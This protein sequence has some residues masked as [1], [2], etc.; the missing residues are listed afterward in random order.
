[1]NQ[2]KITESPVA[3]ARVTL[4]DPGG[5]TL[6][7]ADLWWRDTPLHEGRKIGTIGGFHATDSAAS[8]VILD[9]ATDH[10]RAHGIDT[11]VGPMDGNTWKRYRFV[12]NSNARRPFL[13]EPENPPNF[14]D[15]WLEAGFTELSRYSSSVIPLDGTNAVSPALKR[16]ILSSGITIDHLVPDNFEDE[17][18]SIHTLSLKSFANNFLYTPIDAHDFLS[19]YTKMREHIDPEFVKLARRDGELVGFVFGIAD[20]AAMQRGEPPALIVKTLAVDPSSR[21]AGLGSVLV[22]A[23]HQTGELKGHTEAIHALQHE[24]NTS[25]KITG[26]RQ[27]TPFRQ[28]ALFIKNT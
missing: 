14:P 25:L 21:A 19:A 4:A 11:A 26:R 28:Y 23:L 5:N 13:L 6:A 27:G 20:L 9:A 16:R 12:I 17:L 18:R 7:Q 15:W 22:D 2:A 24:S 3:D 8:R 1:M 10:L